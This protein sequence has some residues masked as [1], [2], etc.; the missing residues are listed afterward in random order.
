MTYS[1]L[2]I[3]KFLKAQIKSRLKKGPPQ[4]QSSY[5]VYRLNFE[6][7]KW[8]EKTMRDLQ[9]LTSSFLRPPP[10]RV[11]QCQHMATPSPLKSADVLYGWSLWILTASIQSYRSWQNVKTVYESV[12]D[13]NGQNASLCIL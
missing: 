13:T 10:P 4:K 6:Q 11:I 12:P 5:F 2:F 8:L 7:T 1:L 9:K 3:C